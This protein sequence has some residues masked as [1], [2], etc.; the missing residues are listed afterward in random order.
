MV[1]QEGDGWGMW[2]EWWGAYRVLVGKLEGKGPPGITRN[3]WQDNIKVDLKERFWNVASGMVP[4]ELCWGNLRE[5]D[6]L[7]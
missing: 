5:R 3:R 6:H 2:H 7:E 1:N 4:I